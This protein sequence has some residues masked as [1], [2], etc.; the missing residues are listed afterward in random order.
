MATVLVVDDSP[1]D[2]HLVGEYLGEDAD[3]EVQYAGHGTEALAKME[4]AVPDLIVTDLMMPEMDGLELV[5]T[6]K[7]KYPFV[8]VVVMTC[9]GSEEIAVESLQRGAASYVPKSALAR[10]L[11]NTVHRV[12]A[13]SSQER[14]H[15]RLMGCMTRSDCTFV[16]DNDC[17]LFAPLITYLQDNIAQMGLFAGADRM[18]IGIALEESLANAMYHGN[19]QVGS[20][21]RQEDD[22]VYCAL[23]QERA[24]RPPYRDRRIHLAATLSCNGATFVIRDEGSGFDPSTLPD[25][26]DPDNLEKLSGRGVLLMRTFMDEVVYNDAGNA[27]TLIK[28]RDSSDDLIENGDF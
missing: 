24:G 7:D 26:T 8:P 17:T 27:V 9:R 28:H 1:T 14:S 25:P 2:R 21:L 18:R 3:L 5:A 23:V 13:V 15:T 11:L 6:V 20:E 22:Q 19:L 12:L 4:H 16:L 10:R